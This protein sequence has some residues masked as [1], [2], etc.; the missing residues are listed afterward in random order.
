M[1][2][3]IPDF[4]IRPFNTFGMDVTCRKWIDYTEAEDLPVIFSRIKGEKFRCI[5]A[6]SNMLFTGR[7]DGNLLHS[8]ILTVD[9]SPAGDGEVNIRVGSG[10]CMDRLI[11]QT[12][13]NGLWGLE[14]LSGIPGDAGAA[15]VQN[16]GAYGVEIKD[17]LESVEC[18]DVETGSFVVI[19]ASDCRYSYRFS[20]FKLTENRFRY[21]ITAIN[22]KLS[23]K[24]QPKLNYG[25]LSTVLA[26]NPA[27]TSADIRDAVI[28]VRSLKLPEP[29]EVGSA[30]SFFKN[31]VVNE[32]KFAEILAD[33]RQSD[34]SEATVPHYP[35]DNGVKI[36]A[37]WLI[38]RCGFKGKVKGNAAVWHK[39]PLVI[40]NHTGSA[41][42]EE[43]VALENEIRNSIVQRFGIE[44]E[45]EVDHI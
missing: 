28:K 42:P 21:I 25:N 30:G 35:M 3:E 10:V 5:G 23:R 14:N 29:S 17:V 19:P 41:S 36:P 31:P 22:I 4:N 27:P 2:T 39:Q 20:M 11:E 44:L 33:V 15:A 16:V 43:I 32:D 26:D 45:A 6:G 34:G 12:V 24:P 40:V 7:Y 9:A 13:E 37:A 1:I 8:S 38:E 18:Y